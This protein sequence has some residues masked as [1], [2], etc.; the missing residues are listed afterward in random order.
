[1][2]FLVDYLQHRYIR[3]GEELR[4]EPGN[5]NVIVTEIEGF[6]KYAAVRYGRRK[7]SSYPG[8]IRR[9]GIRRDKNGKWFYVFG[10]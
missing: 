3:K 5:E 9:D 1:M 6:G 4:L 7:G 2:C 8:A 10:D